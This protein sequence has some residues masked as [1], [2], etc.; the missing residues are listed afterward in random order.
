MVGLRGGGGEGRREKRQIGRKADRQID[1]KIQSIDSY[2]IL[3]LFPSHITYPH[4]GQVQSARRWMDDAG[5]NNGS[6][7]WKRKGRVF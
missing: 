1:G 3:E 7:D 4:T 6:A 2:L 5:I